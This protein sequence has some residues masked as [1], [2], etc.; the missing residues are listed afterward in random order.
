M[1]RCYS[2]GH[3]LGCIIIVCINCCIYIHNDGSCDLN[4]DIQS[5][6]GTILDLIIHRLYRAHCIDEHLPHY[7]CDDKC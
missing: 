5:I 2:D 7:E 3:V 6:A 1:R 4:E